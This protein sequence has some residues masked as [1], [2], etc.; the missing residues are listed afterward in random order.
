MACC[1]NKVSQARFLWI[2]QLSNDRYGNADKAIHY[3]E[4]ALELARQLDQRELIA[5]VLNDLGQSYYHIG[6]FKR[7]KQVG[8]EAV[9]LWRS[10]ENKAMQADALSTLVFAYYLAAD[11]EKAFQTADEA[12]QISRSIENL[13]GQ[14]YSQM[15][16]G[17]A[18]FELGD[19]GKAIEVMEDCLRLSRA[20]G[21]VAPELTT[22]S[23]LARTY[24]EL[25]APDLATELAEKAYQ[26][27]SRWADSSWLQ[28]S[29]YGKIIVFSVIGDVEQARPWVQQLTDLYPK[30]T[31][32]GDSELLILFALT[33][34]YLADHNYEE[35][36]KYGSRFKNLADANIRVIDSRVSFWQAKALIGLGQKEEGFQYLRTAYADAQELNQLWMLW[37]TLLEMAEIEM[38]RGELQEADSHMAQ[39]VEIVTNIADHIS[40]PGLRESFLSRSDIPQL[41]EKVA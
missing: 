31:L 21:F 20:A 9:Q 13:W 10:L 26:A 2:L 30:L 39:A 19:P 3:G 24:A 7:G 28:Y 36:L 15:Y 34:F 35:V 23:D 38:S 5:Y 4:Q 14:A 37:Q 32:G 33:E 25:G 40:Q 11:Y 22:Q 8:E 18:Y 29:L 12:L 16:I 27:V 17:P 41:L 6:D 1:S